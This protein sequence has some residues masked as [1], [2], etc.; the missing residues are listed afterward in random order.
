MG[1]TLPDLVIESVIREGLADIKASPEKLDNI[2]SSFTSS[3]ISP[4]YGNA[5]ITALKAILA[6]KDIAVVHSYYET[7]MQEPCISIQLGSDV[8]NAALAHLDDFED[9]SEVARDPDDMLIVEDIIP[10]SYDST[11]GIIRVSDGTD[12]SDVFKGQIFVDAADTELSILM[13][14]NETGNKQVVVAV[15]SEVDITNFCYIKSSI[16]YLQYEE[17][18]VISNVQLVLGVHSKDALMAKYLYILVKF[19]LISRKKDLINRNFFN[20]SF[21]G[22][23]FTRNM[24]YQG[25]RVFT[26][27]LTVTGK[28][29]DNYRS[30]LVTP[31]ENLDVIV[32][33]PKDEVTTEDLGMED[34]TIQVSDE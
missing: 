31:I 21:S 18:G 9:D 16:D 12:L 20:L 10:S 33:V 27:F 30:D 32:I 29:E 1:F 17:R 13:V 6:A 3:F 7:A 23:D 4:K 15:L 19:F 2:F 28:I 14:V 24:Q 5:E 34:S 26:R 8:E 11:T 25:D 22:S